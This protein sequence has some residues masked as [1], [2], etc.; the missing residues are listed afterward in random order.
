M[1]LW[2]GDINKT[3]CK[4]HL[5]VRQ[6]QTYMQKKH[7]APENIIN[8]WLTY[9]EYIIVPYVFGLKYLEKKGGTMYPNISHVEIQGQIKAELRDYQQKVFDF[10]ME[11]LPTTKGI[12][13]ELYTGSG[14]SLTSIAIA[15][16]LGKRILIVTTNVSLATQWSK[17]MKTKTNCEVGLVGLKGLDNPKA[18][19]VCCYSVR[20]SKLTDEEKL[21]FGTLIID[22]V[23]YHCTDG[24]SANLLLI[25][26]EYIIGCTARLERANELHLIGKL[27]IGKSIYTLKY[28]G[29]LTVCKY[30]TGIIPKIE[31]NVNNDT[32]FAKSNASIYTETYI[33]LLL[34]ITAIL[35]IK[36]Y[37]VLILFHVKE[38]LE[39]VWEYFT[40]NSDII[41][42]A[43]YK[44]MEAYDDCQCLLGT[45][46]KIKYG[47]DEEEIARNWNGSR[48]SAF[49]LTDSLKDIN[50]VEQAVG[51]I[52]RSSNPLVVD[53]VHEH[54]IYRNHFNERKNYYEE[55][56]PETNKIYKRLRYVDFEDI[57]DYE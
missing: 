1:S 27:L 8:Y 31:K 35:I 46:A 28:E 45:Y 23:P 34:E 14:K 53:M 42:S 56:N 15:L 36:G 48:L 25:Q 51:R 24:Y 19:I 4:N 41:V 22:E 12:L 30:E 39:A 38:S 10:A 33:H 57:P 6:A 2:I 52:L 50:A 47:F 55:R 49:L 9:E 54:K 29:K 32:I 13:L 5:V 17:S 20:I 11:T 16:A 43:F 26:P 44:D 3:D 40:N 37:K 21:S 7:N 18:Q